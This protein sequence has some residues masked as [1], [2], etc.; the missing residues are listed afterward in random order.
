MLS[1]YQDS[2]RDDNFFH[3]QSDN[4]LIKSIMDEEK[5]ISI[6]LPSKTDNEEFKSFPQLSENQDNS[7]ILGMCLMLF[8]V[9]SYSFLAF[10]LKVAYSINPNINN[11]DMVLTRSVLSFTSCIFYV[12]YKNVNVVK[13]N[14]NGVSLFLTSICGVLCYIL[15]VWSISYIS[16]TKSALIIYS[17]PVIVAIL[18]YL[19]LNEKV[20]FYDVIIIVLVLGG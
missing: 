1:F 16:A 8:S 2:S 4:S 11:W 10:L 13:F 20:G 12:Y 17:N 5:R 6:E 15:Q 7:I 3:N 9:T 19:F 18:A 14:G